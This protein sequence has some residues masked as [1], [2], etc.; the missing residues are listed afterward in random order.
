MNRL[1][2][3][4]HAA[5]LRGELEPNILPRQLRALERVAARLID[6]RPAPPPRFRDRLEGRV[7]ELATQTHSPGP[8]TWRLG[9]AICL[10]SGFAL[11]F[12]AAILS[13]A[14]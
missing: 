6:E 1:D 5:E 11:L 14:G 9:A 7:R 4:K 13:A 3:R 12:V 2:S 10:G 8:P